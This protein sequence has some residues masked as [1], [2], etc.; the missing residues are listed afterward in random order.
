MRISTIHRDL[1]LRLGR[2]LHLR[3]RARVDYDGAAPLPRLGG[4]LST[5]RSSCHRRR[6]W[7]L[8]VDECVAP[9]PRLRPTARCMHGHDEMHM[10]KDLACSRKHARARARSTMHIEFLST[11]TPTVDPSPKSCSNLLSSRTPL[12]CACNAHNV[13]ELLWLSRPL[14]RAGQHE[15][16]RRIGMNTWLSSPWARA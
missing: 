10:F 14:S 8:Q 3:R 4:D 12:P 1:E 13:R 9:L 11:S 5:A 7:Q 16:I 15:H 6:R 2:L